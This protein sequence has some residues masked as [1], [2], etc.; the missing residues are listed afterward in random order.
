ME[1]Q[2]GREGKRRVSESIRTVNY[3]LD[4]VTHKWQSQ[5]ENK[6]SVFRSHLHVQSAVSLN[7]ALRVGLIH[8]AWYN[9]RFHTRWNNVEYISFST[10]NCHKCTKSMSRIVL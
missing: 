3:S 2:E 10:Q 8:A 1:R 7:P 5:V 4:L 6:H 9:V